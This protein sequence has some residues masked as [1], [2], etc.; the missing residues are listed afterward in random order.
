MLQEV[1]RIETGDGTAGVG[2]LTREAF[3]DGLRCMEGM[4]I[5]PP[6]EDVL[7]MA[8]LLMAILAKSPED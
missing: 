7:A 1:L 4:V 6:L 8:E 2:H 3:C 5:P